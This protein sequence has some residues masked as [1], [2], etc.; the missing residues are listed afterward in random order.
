MGRNLTAGTNR[1]GLV[2]EFDAFAPRRPGFDEIVS[3]ARAR[4]AGTFVEE[5][6][7]SREVARAGGYAM[8]R[9]RLGTDEFRRDSERVDPDF[10]VSTDLAPHTAVFGV[11]DGDGRAQAIVQAYGLSRHGYGVSGL[12]GAPGRSVGADVMARFLALVDAP[13]TPGTDHRASDL[14]DVRFDADS[15]WVAQAPRHLVRVTFERVCFD[16]RPALRETTDV[17]VPLQPG[18][19]LAD[20]DPEA[21]DAAAHRYKSFGL[22]LVGKGVR[23][24]FSSWWAKDAPVVVKV[25]GDGLDAEI[26]PEEAPGEEPAGPRF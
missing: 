3:Q 5:G 8:V 24:G 12:Y 23:P 11:L 26:G 13:P 9:Y 14:F 16:T 4:R 20:P 15:G 17:L 7:V 18:Y 21:A 19:D 25:V 22:A 2:G 6:R 10:F 1:H